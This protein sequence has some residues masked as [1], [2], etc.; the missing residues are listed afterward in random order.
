[1][2]NKQIAWCLLLP[3]GQLAL[4]FWTGDES[5]SGPF[6]VAWFAITVAAHLWAGRNAAQRRWLAGR[7]QIPETTPKLL[8]GART[9]LGRHSRTS[10]RVK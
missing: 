9:G 3:T 8:C 10:V 6:T 4:A 2:T 5:L 1:M 7:R